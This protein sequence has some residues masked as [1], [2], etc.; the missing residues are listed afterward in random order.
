MTDSKLKTLEV[1]TLE[2]TTVYS[3]VGTVD[4]S[5][6]VDSDLSHYVNPDTVKLIGD[7]MI[8]EGASGSYHVEASSVSTEDRQITLTIN[9]GTANRFDDNSQIF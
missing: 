5:G 9:D 4:A 3:N 2:S 6:I 7:S 8:M 1:E